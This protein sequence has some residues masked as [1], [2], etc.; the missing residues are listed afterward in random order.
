ML[1]KVLYCITKMKPI[2]LRFKSW[3][4]RQTGQNY[5]NITQSLN[6]G[7]VFCRTRG[8]SKSTVWQTDW[9]TEGRQTMWSLWAF[10]VAGTKKISHTYFWFWLTYMFFWYWEF[11]KFYEPEVVTGGECIAEMREMRTIHVSVCRVL[12]PDAYHLLSKRAEINLGMLSGTCW[13][14]F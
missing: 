6:F 2:T 9:W 1:L 11:K 4:K 13:V 12:R 5:Y 8:A 14:Y 7:P 10:C 3:D